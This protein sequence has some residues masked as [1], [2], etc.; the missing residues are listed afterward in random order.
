MMELEASIDLFEG[1]GGTEGTAR[2]DAGLRGSPEIPD[3]GT[4]GTD[5]GEPTRWGDG[6]KPPL[7]AM[8]EAIDPL[9]QPP[10]H[11]AAV[12][13]ERPSFATYDDWREV[14][15]IKLKPGLWYHGMKGGKKDQPPEPFDQWICA[16]IHAEAITASEAGDNFGLLLRF[17]N[18]YG[19]WRE[20]AMPMHMLKG[21]GDDMRGELLNLGVRIDHAGRGL[22]ANWMM[23]RHP[24]RRVIAATRTGW[25]GPALFIMP[26]RNIGT[27]DVIYQSEHAAHDAFKQ[28]GTLDGWRDAVGRLCQGNRV[29]VL[30]VAAALAGPLLM[31]TH[32][33]GGGIHLVGDSSSGKSTALQCAASVWGAPDFIRTWRAT[34]NGLEGTAA[35]LNDTALILD[36]IG[37]VDPREVGAIVYAIGNGTGKQR[38]ARTGAARAVQRWRLILLSSGERSLSA[39]MAEGGKAAKAGQEVRLLD[40][41][42]ARQ[43][44]AFD[45]L[46]GLAS[47]RELSDTLKTAC[48]TDYGHIGPAFIERLIADERDFAGMLAE[49]LT[50]PDFAAT[51]GLEGRAASSF[52]LAGIA[53]ELGIEWGLL[54]WPEGEAMQAA[55]WGY[56]TWRGNRGTGQTETGQ[57]LRAVSDFIAK[58]GD[59]RFSAYLDH[60]A[61]VRD[62]AG[63]W[64]DAPLDAGRVYLFTPAGLREAA[65]GFDFKRA[66]AALD[67]AG[68]IVERDHGKRTK[69]MRAGGNPQSLYAILPADL[70][71]E[72]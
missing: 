21:S 12:K 26:G 69:K 4:G 1:T 37:E 50:L 47:G 56:A 16:P 13:V 6:I 31:R 20:W 63:W 34:G 65:Q 22:L 40:V 71:G 59:A 58:H 49:A 10:E 38:A 41:P 39:H 53:G 57:I 8:P 48:A 27:G 51:H 25:H 3:E 68:W 36:E 54:P 5:H 66:L 28:S 23:S 35:A 11:P 64:K 30:A 67:E 44:G 43:H 55:V 2:S 33:Q 46:H 45:E 15:G 42:V 17:L 24:K 70:E 60:E 7:F 14:D 18:A 9:Q 29:A 62:R 52:A 61:S 72:S 19:R 32:R